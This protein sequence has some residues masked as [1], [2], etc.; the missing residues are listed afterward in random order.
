MR[1]IAAAVLVGAAML[2]ACSDSANYY[3]EE[4]GNLYARPVEETQRR[5][6]ERREIIHWAQDPRKKKRIGY[7]EK[8][9]I[10]VKG[11][12]DTRRCWYI[13]DAR[14]L[15]NIGF[16]TEEGRF[17]RYD[18]NGRLGEYVGPWNYHP[19][20]LRVFFGISSGDNLDL[21]EIDPYR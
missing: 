5:V 17:Y 2:A 1:L 10:Q 13:K 18:A 7:L 16:I 14:G 12:R 21:E 6:L 8:E 20:G 9:E 4:W 11:S 3:G 15:Q 19:Q